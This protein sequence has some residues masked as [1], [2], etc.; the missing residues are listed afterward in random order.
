VVSVVFAA[1]VTAP[2]RAQENYQYPSKVQIAWNQLYNYDQVVDICRQLVAAYPDMLR[3]ESIGKSVEGRDMWLLTLNVQKT[4]RDTEKPAMYIDGNIHGNEVQATEVILYT[5]WYLTKSYGKVPELTELMDRVAFYF[6]PMVNPDGRAH[7]F[8]SPNTMSS[9][10]SGKKPVDSDGDGLFDEDGP[11]DLDGDGFILQM[12]REDPNGRVRESPE[13]YRLMVP[14]DPQAKGEFKRYTPLGEEGIDDDE[15]GLVN[16]DGPGG[17]DPNRNWPAD[18][19]PNYIQRGSGDYPL[20]LPESA[21]IAR[22][23]LA[24]PNIAGVQAYHNNG[25]MILRGPGVSY[26]QYPGA[27]IRVYDKIAQRG[28]KMLP[29]YRYL[30][31][32]SGLYIVHGGFV[33]W[34]AEDLGIISFTNEL[35]TERKYYPNKTENATQ[36]EELEFSDYVMFGQSYVPWKKFNHPVYGE[37]ELGGW[38]KMTGRV[39]PSFH[40]EEECHRNFAFTVYHAAQMPLVELDN[41]EVRPLGGD[42][43]RIRVDVHNRRVIPTTTAQRAARAVGARDYVEISGDKLKVV[44]GGTIAN[45]FTAPFQFVEHNPQKLWIDDGIPGE[46]YRTFQWIVS[47][48]GSATIRFFS[49][50]AKDVPWTFDLKQTPRTPSQTRP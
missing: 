24:H 27:D 38:V 16:E 21:S 10:R 2:L 23:I 49:D 18:W 19:Q 26:V 20:S 7:W 34:T 13:D 17:Y 46:S 3:M 39:P 35:W 25:G 5:I 14:V 37:I 28:E 47:G 22:F 4:G 50:R 42:L 36:K 12:R 44:A 31:I 45:R 30:V 48:S 8:S 32:W 33:N 11:N 9:S 43:W 41:L 40:L 29:F 6:V 15:D 1:L